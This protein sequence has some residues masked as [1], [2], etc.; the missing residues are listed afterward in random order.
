[1]GHD[2]QYHERS[3]LKVLGNEGQHRS[4]WRSI[5]SYPAKVGC[6]VSAL[7]DELENSEFD[8]GERPRI[9]SETIEP[10]HALGREQWAL[11][12]SNEVLRKA[13]AFSLMVERERLSRLML[14]STRLWNLVT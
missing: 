7:N 2:A 4:H 8:D 1:M 14:F 5:T 9:P 11:R 10:M 12:R 6:S 3:E 13:L